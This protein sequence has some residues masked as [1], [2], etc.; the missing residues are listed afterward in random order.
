[1]SGSLLWFDTLNHIF[2]DTII[3]STHDGLIMLV[4][5]MGSVIEAHVIVI[6]IMVLVRRKVRIEIVIIHG[7]L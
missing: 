4:T 5:A 6:V 1:M 7:V 3:A 2:I